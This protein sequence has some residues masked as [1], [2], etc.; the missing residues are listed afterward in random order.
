VVQESKEKTVDQEKEK[1]DKN[2]MDQPQKTKE[3]SEDIKNK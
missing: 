3:E 2:Q 1:T